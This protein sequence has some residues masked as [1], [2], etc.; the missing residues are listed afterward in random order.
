MTAN[1]KAVQV[2]IDAGTAS[3]AGHQRAHDLRIGPQPDYVDASRISLNRVLIEPLTGVLLREVCETR[4]SQRETKRAMK[5]NAAV[6]VS[7]IITFGHEA[8]P[9]FEALTTEQQ[10]AAF[11]EVAEAVAARIGTTVSG[12]VFHSDEAA[13][14]AH[15]QCPAVALDGQPV[16]KLAKRDALRDMQTIAAEIMGRHAPGIE[17]GKPRWQ[18][19]AE[20]EEYA[21]T[22]HRS[23]TM[24]RAV[25]PAEIAEAEAKL[26]ETA[27]ALATNIERAA[28]ARAD[29]DKA[30]FQNG[31]ESDKA[32]KIR[33]RA[34]TYEKRVKAAE[35]KV[36]NATDELEAMQ[37]SLAKIERS[38]VS[39][40]A[41]LEKLQGETVET[42]ATLDGLEKSVAQKKTKIDSLRMRLQSLNAA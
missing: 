17:R 34:E 11:R 1:K 35:T 31:V 18:R 7:G 10:D 12:L 38:T 14:H 9:L 27:K 40:V 32:T 29:L 42:K 41:N 19:I 16:S 2:R 24:M 23:A 13:P 25:L 15:F 22:V 8:Q 39:A 3:Q 4:R 6:C 20:G 36:A 37:A 28:K 30:V 33:K 21:D 5:S 26:A